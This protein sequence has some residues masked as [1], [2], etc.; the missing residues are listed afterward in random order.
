MEAATATAAVARV[1]AAKAAAARAAAVREE[2]AT[3]AAGLVMWFAV[4][5]GPWPWCARPRG[6][7][8]LRP[9]LRS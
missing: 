6:N 7:A 3:A 4:F 8:P 9:M 5:A 2:A 1:A